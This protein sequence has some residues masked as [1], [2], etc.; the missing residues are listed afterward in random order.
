M[1]SKVNTFYC[2]AVHMS[3]NVAVATIGIAIAAT[4]LL[5]GSTQ[6]NG[7]LGR[8]TNGEWEAQAYNHLCV[9]ITHL[10]DL[11]IQDFVTSLPEVAHAH[12]NAS[13]PEREKSCL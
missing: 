7:N 3:I 11:L 4:T 1:R 6:L 10:L 9:Q 2:A 5:P 13:V 12:A 8:K